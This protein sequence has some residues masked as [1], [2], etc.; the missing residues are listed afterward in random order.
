MIANRLEPWNKFAPTG[1]VMEHLPVGIQPA[2]TEIR[3]PIQ[4]HAQIQGAWLFLVNRG[5][6]KSTP[7]MILAI[8]PGCAPRKS[9]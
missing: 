1:A 9:D 2:G 7:S 4:P 5:E 8:L 6:P 3:V